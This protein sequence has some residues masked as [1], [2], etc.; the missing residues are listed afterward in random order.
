MLV[1]GRWAPEW[2][3]ACGYEEDNGELK[4]FGRTY[5]DSQKYFDEKIL[6]NQSTNVPE[7]EIYTDNQYFY[8]NAF[9]GWYPEALTRFYDKRCEPISKKQA[10]KNRWK[11]VLRCLSNRQMTYINSVMMLMMC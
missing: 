1:A 2:T 8:F 3:V 11:P 5:F 7:N 6:E 10:L 9:P 4:F